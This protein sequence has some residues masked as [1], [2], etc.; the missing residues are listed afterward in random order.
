M[1]SIASRPDELLPG[2]A[3]EREPP[4]LLGGVWEPVLVVSRQPDR[5]LHRFN[6]TV[7]PFRGA[8]HSDTA[9]AD[10][11]GGASSTGAVSV[12]ARCDP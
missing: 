6:Y 7:L 5:R 10:A 4:S 11:A 8:E 1:R 2:E 9:A 3:V 12:G